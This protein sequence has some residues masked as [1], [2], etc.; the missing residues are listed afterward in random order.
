VDA[1]T[2]AALVREDQ[3]EAGQVKALEG[4][5]IE[6]QVGLVVAVHAGQPV[7]ERHADRPVPVVGGHQ[8]RRVD[9]REH[10]RAREGADQ[11]V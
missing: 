4:E 1:V 3:V 8:V 11:H 10:G 7:H 2:E 9:R 5:G 6:R